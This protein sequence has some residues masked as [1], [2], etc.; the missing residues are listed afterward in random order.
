MSGDIKLNSQHSQQAQKIII[1]GRPDRGINDN[2]YVCYVLPEY[3]LVIFEWNQK[4]SAKVVV[5]DIT[6]IEF[7]IRRI[8]LGYECIEIPKTRNG[9]GFI[10]YKLFKKYQ[11][12]LIEHYDKDIY[13]DEQMQTFLLAAL[14]DDENMLKS[15]MR[16]INWHLEPP[17]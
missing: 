13:L 1:F 15:T 17:F 2:I 9:I 5:E 3:D 16:R 11:K 4:T 7:L 12:L 6:L 14:Y 10:N 8:Q